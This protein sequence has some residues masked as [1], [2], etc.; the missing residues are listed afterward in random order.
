MCALSYRFY[1]LFLVAH[2]FCMFSIKSLI[3]SLLSNFTL[4]LQSFFSRCCSHLPVGRF[5]VVELLPASSYQI[6]VTGYQLL[7]LPDYRSSRFL[8]ICGTSNGICAV[9]GFAQLKYGMLVKQSKD[10]SLA[11]DNMIYCLGKYIKWQKVA[12]YDIVLLH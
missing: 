7:E 11:L 8:R 10:D 2:F 3:F 9:I 12:Q 1:Y 5:S 6:P 4:F